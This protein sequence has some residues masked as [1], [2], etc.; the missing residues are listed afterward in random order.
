MERHNLICSLIG[1]YI[2]KKK[3]QNANDL[4]IAVDNHLISHNMTPLGSE[5]GD[6]QLTQD[7]LDET[8]ISVLSMGVNR[9]QR[10]RLS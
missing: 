4:K 3:I 8:I 6:D 5:E 10:R 7:L 1:F 9:E 2:A